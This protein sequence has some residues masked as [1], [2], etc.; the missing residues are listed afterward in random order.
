MSRT[1][2]VLLSLLLVMP[3]S[4]W[5][6]DD[7]AQSLRRDYPTLEFQRITPGPF[8]G[9]YQVVVNQS[10]IL[11]YL[12][13][14]GFLITG[15]IWTRDAQNLTKNAMADLMTQKAALFPL[16]KALVIGNGPHQ[17]IEVVDPDCPYCREGSAFFAGRKDVT[18]YIYLFPL[19]IHPQA[20]AKAAYILS[21]AEPDVAY[22]DVMGGAFDNQELPAFKDNGRLKEHQRLGAEIGIHGTPKYW[23]DGRF[24]AGSNLKLVEQMLSGAQ[25]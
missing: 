1:L 9:A 12:P 16:D 25:N 15:E 18:R 23:V 14:Q 3:L 19:N 17:V 10:E 4:L 24:V 20:E 6:A 5:A 8:D 2:F 22:E 13:R 11:Y 7:V 21:A